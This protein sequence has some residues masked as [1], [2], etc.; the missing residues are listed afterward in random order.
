VAVMAFLSDNHVEPDV[1]VETFLLSPP[2]D[3]SS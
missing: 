3:E 2:A 1:A